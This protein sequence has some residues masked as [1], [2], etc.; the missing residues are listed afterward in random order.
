MLAQTY[1]EMKMLDPPQARAGHVGDGMTRK[2]MGTTTNQK[3]KG[4]TER[5]IAVTISYN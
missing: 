3:K 4:Q 1:K 2:G 5:E